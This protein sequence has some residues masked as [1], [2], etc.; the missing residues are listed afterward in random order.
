M[1]SYASQQPASQRTCFKVLMMTTREKTERYCR[2][3][4]D[5]SFSGAEVLPET[6]MLHIFPRAAMAQ[7]NR[8]ERG[9]VKDVSTNTS[10]QVSCGLPHST[11]YV[12]SNCF[13]RIFCQIVLIINRFCKLDPQFLANVPYSRLTCEDLPPWELRELELRRKLLFSLILF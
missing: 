11:L 7:E 5:L 1:A 2:L 3:K 4:M 10:C 8:L 9:K 6:R 13:C 12:H